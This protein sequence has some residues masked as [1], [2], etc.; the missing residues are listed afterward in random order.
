MN[1]ADPLE[2]AMN[3]FPDAKI[4]LAPTIYVT[5]KELPAAKVKFQMR[6]RRMDTR[7]FTSSLAFYS[8]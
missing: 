3:V 7:K 5:V 6:F 1:G 2:V 8:Q 4:A